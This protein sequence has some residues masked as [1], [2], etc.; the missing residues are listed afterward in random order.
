VTVGV[1]EVG[2][3]HKS[4]KDVLAELTALLQESKHSGQNRIVWPGKVI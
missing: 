4:A 2:F 3:R 1:I